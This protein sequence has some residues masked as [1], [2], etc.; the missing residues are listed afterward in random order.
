MQRYMIERNIPGVGGLGPDQLKGAAMTSNEALAKLTPRIKWIESYVT[1][2][3]TFC[4]YE[5]E[6]EA[7]I[8][9]HSEMSGFPANVITA[10]GGMIDPS[11]AD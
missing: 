6:D 5:A 8:M 1:A 3:K 9:E 4:V 11:T 7:V 10:I 2:E